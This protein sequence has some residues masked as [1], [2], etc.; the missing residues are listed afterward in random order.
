MTSDFELAFRQLLKP[1]VREVAVEFFKDRQAPD[2]P[3][4]EF[5]LPNGPFS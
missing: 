3:Q 2:R 4:S 5:D 1:V